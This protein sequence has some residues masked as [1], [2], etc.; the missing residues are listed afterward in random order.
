MGYVYFMEKHILLYYGLLEISLSSGGSR[1]GSRERVAGF[2]IAGGSFST[3][4]C[5]FVIEEKG[6]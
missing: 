5:D 3:F 1:I 2:K 6:K 4:A